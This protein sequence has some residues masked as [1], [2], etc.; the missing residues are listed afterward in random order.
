MKENPNRLPSLI[1]GHLGTW[2]RAVQLQRSRISGAD[3]G[4]DRQIDSYFCVIAL[5][6]VFRAAVE[7]K[8]I[9]GDALLDQA[10]KR[11]EK[12]LPDAQGLRDILIHFDAYERGKGKLQKAGA[13]GTLDIFTESGE[14]RFWLRINDLKIE[15]GLA[16]QNAEDLAY[17]AMNAADRHSER[18][19]QKRVTK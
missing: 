4:T 8:R 5:S 15:L 7:M 1:K 18:V 3:F 16:L 10:C 19:K 6:Q 2:T 11:F 13:M 9:T 14:T 17:E 12:D